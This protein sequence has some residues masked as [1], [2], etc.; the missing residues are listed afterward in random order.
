MVTWTFF[1][2][3]RGS[4]YSTCFERRRNVCRQKTSGGL[5]ARR[6]MVMFLRR[7]AHKATERWQQ[8]SLELFGN[9]DPRSR[10]R[11]PTPG[12][13]GNPCCI[14][15]RLRI[16]RRRDRHQRLPPPK[17]E[18]SI[19]RSL[20]SA[21]H[22]MRFHVSS[23][24][25]QGASCHLSRATGVTDQCNDPTQSPSAAIAQGKSRCDLHLSLSIDRWDVNRQQSKL[26]RDESSSS[27]DYTLEMRSNILPSHDSMWPVS[28]T[29]RAGRLIP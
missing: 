20:S 2:P 5:H 24:G 28:E 6:Q 26:P 29:G 18:C 7:H 17:P 27:L 23:I 11:S 1:S 15:R 10:S 12:G 13:V 4:L 19:Q 14:C 9:F 16:E 25:H 8:A 3:V 21:F 22:T